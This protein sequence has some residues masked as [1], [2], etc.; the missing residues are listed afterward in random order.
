M[1][2]MRTKKQKMAKIAALAVFY[3]SGPLFLALTDPQQLPLPII[4]L[5]FVWLFLAIFVGVNGLV[6]MRVSGL[7]PKRRIVVAGVCATLPVLLVVFESI[8]QLTI[9]DVLIVFALVATMSFYVLRADF[10]K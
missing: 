8:H 1:R 10:I 9:K 7:V 5:P 4:L 6:K 3:S 2:G